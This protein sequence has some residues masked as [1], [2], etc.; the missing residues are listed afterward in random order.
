[1]VRRR[2]TCAVSFYISSSAFDDIDGVTVFLGMALGT[3]GI[4]LELGGRSPSVR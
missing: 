2:L 4:L 3:A 1:L